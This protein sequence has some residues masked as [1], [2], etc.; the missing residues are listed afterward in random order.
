MICTPLAQA[1]KHMTD[2]EQA[3]VASDSKGRVCNFGPNHDECYDQ[4]IKHTSAQTNSE[5]HITE[6]VIVITYNVPNQGIN[7]IYRYI[8]EAPGTGGVMYVNLTGADDG[9]FQWIEGTRDSDA[10][11]HPGDKFTVSVSRYVSNGHLS[12]LYK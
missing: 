1:K 10:P 4:F 9:L 12:S 6:G 8:D 3:G 7:L 5:K 2:T 11:Y